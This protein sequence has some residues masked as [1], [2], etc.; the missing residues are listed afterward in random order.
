MSLNVFLTSLT[1]SSP[2]LTPP[3]SV[4]CKIC[5]DTTF[6]TSGNPIFFACLAASSAEVTSAKG[7]TLTP[8]VLRI[9]FDNS[10]VITL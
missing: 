4:L 8:Y 1:L 2:T 5:G 10:S 6:I 7:G 9:D 3:T